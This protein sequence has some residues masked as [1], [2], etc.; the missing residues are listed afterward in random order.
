MKIG[1]AARIACIGVFAS[2]LAGCAQQTART[3]SKGIEKIQHILVI[4][5]EN[6]SFDNLYGLFPGANGIASATSAQYTQVDN[7]GKA[8]AHLPPVW[9]GKDPDPA[10]PKDLPN[11]PFRIDAPPINLPLSVAT[12]DLVHKFYQNQEQINEGRLDRYVAASDAGALVMGYYDGS[13]LPLWKWAQEYTLA[14]NF[15]TAAFGGSYLNHFWLVCACTPEHRDAPANLRAQLD[16]NFLKR[17]SESPASA[18]DGAPIFA[19]DGD[20]TTDGWSVNTTQPPYQPS[21]V[22]PAKGGDPRLADVSKH[23]LPPQS[24]KTI[25][26]TLSA[27]GISWAWYAGAW[28]VALQD[29]MQDP[30]APRKMINTRADGAPYFVTHH[31]PFN[32]FAR[33]APGAADR[34]A[35]LKDY[36]ELAASIDRGELPQVAFY[37]PQGTL[38]EHAGYADVLAGDTHIAEVIARIKA[39]QLWA[40]TAIIVTYDENGGF[41]DHVKPPVGDRWG[42]GPRIPALLISPYA[43]RN[44]VDHTQYDTT[45]ILKFITRRFGL[46]PLPG[47]RSQ[48]GDLTA[49]FDFTQ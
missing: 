3:A 4:Y 12:R 29:G 30:A 16:G 32:Y 8:L 48:V 40:S 45:S 20:V 17:K 24:A 21:R 25:G 15:F 33:F 14:D 38:N 31:Q 22:P 10:F 39:S 26:D 2:A 1:A 9:K 7:D 44:F 5:A 18:V 37:K 13:N 27:K 43:K 35:H 46:E 42:P 36:A 34:G 23:P 19:L 41:W 6:R 47:V 49:A 11:R 28:N